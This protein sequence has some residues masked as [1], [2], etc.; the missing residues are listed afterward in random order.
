[1]ESALAV[2]R[3]GM[4]NGEERGERTLPERVQVE[5]GRIHREGSS[6]SSLSS[7]SAEDDVRVSEPFV[8][9]TFRERDG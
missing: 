7:A 5:E 1:M 9:R 8:Q 2:V 6:A 4:K 3:T